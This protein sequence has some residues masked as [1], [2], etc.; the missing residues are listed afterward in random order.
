V[1]RAGLADAEVADAEQLAQPV[2]VQGQGD[3]LG[4]SAGSTG[5]LSA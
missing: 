2:A 1:N 4:V 3:A 5:K